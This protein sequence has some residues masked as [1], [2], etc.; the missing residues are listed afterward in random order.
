VTLS[1]K[2]DAIVRALEFYGEKENYRG[3][4]LVS[5]EQ[6]FPLDSMSAVHCDRGQ[7]A[8][9]VLNVLHREID[10]HLSR[11]SSTAT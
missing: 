5:A 6:Q 7:I 8:R 2:I 1:E 4:I 10:S 9:D 11:E 3:P